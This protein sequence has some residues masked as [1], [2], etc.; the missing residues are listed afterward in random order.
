MRL[1]AD[2][3]IPLHLPLKTKVWEST[4]L[5]NVIGAAKNK[6]LYKDLLNYN[7]KEGSTEINWMKLYNEQPNHPSNVRVWYT[8]HKCT[9]INEN[10]NQILRYTDEIVTMKIGF[11]QTSNTDH[12][13]GILKIPQK[14]IL[15]REPQ[16]IPDKNV[17]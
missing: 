5:R 9:F 10:S 17:R 2:T 16:T 1:A 8:I 15:K 6:S 4:E 13:I 14:N 3:I 11:Y 12:L 7:W